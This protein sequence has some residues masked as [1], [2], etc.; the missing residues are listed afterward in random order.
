M[1]LVKKYQMGEISIIQAVSTHKTLIFEYPAPFYGK[2]HRFPTF[3]DKQKSLKFVIKKFPDMDAVFISSSLSFGVFFLK[4]VKI[5]MT[6]PVFEQLL[7]KYEEYKNMCVAY[8]DLSAHE[9]YHMYCDHQCSGEPNSGGNS[10]YNK[11]DDCDLF[12]RQSNDRTSQDSNS[13]KPSAREIEHNSDDKSKFDE[14]YQIVSL[15]DVKIEKFKK[16][17]II[18]RYNHIVEYENFVI[19]PKPAGTFIGWCNYKITF[20]NKKTL[21]LLTSYSNKRRFSIEASNVSSDYLVINRPKIMPENQIQELTKYINE[22]LALQ[23]GKSL[24]IPVNFETFFIEIIFHILSL[25]EHSAVVV[26]IV[27]PLFKKLDFILNIQSEWLNK[28]FFSISEPFP[29]RKYRNLQVFNS[30]FEASFEKNEKNIIFCSKE[31]FCMLKNKTLLD[32]CEI[33]HIKHYS[34]KQNSCFCSNTVQSVNTAEMPNIKSEHKTDKISVPFESENRKIKDCLPGIESDF[35][36][37]NENEEFTE[38]YFTVK[39]EAT[40]DEILSNFAGKL[41]SG[42]TTYINSEKHT[43]SIYLSSSIHMIK[44]KVILSGTLHNTDFSNYGRIIKFLDDRPCFINEIAKKEDP[45]F[46]DGWFYFLKSKLRIRPLSNG[47]IEYS[48]L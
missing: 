12:A 24:V 1:V 48:Y 44:N 38:K 3:D 2:N 29:I 47:Q 46:I 23:T 27:F 21:L 9:A 16:S 10:C 42:P 40:D 13:A 28:D 20:D 22:Y 19:Q 31:D 11:H 8:T 14:E 15:E 36:E 7:L 39:I 18:L 41:L 37:S 6:K 4:N 33:L 17:V 32:N 35:S 34:A 45:I 26:T 5:Y 30:F 43:E 25:I